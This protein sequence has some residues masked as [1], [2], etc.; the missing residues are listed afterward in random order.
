MWFPPG[1]EGMSVGGTSHRISGKAPGRAL[2]TPSYRRCC[3]GV[4]TRRNERDWER[5]DD[6]RTWKNEIPVKKQ[7]GLTFD[8]AAALS[9]SLVW[10]HVHLIHCGQQLLIGL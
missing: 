7:E 1:H 9:H 5:R 4:E 6:A 8:D 3:L 2:D 10:G